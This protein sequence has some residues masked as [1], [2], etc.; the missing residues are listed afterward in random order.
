MTGSVAK[1]AG[2]DIFADSEMSDDMDAGGI[3]ANAG[4]GKGGAMVINTKRFAV[5][6]GRALTTDMIP[7]PGIDS[8]HVISRTRFHSIHAVVTETGSWYLM[9][10]TV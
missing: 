1:V 5:A 3:N 4:G 6:T 10:I 8:M 2:L 9:N 7:Q